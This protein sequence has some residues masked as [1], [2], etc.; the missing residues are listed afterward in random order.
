MILFS[1]E[2]EHLLDL[3]ASTKLAANE[4]SCH[5]GLGISY[6]SRNSINDNNKMKFGSLIIMACG[7]KSDPRDVCFFIHNV[8]YSSSDHSDFDGN[9]FLIFVLQVFYAS[10][11]TFQMSI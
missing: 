10:D 9:L 1:L 7:C 4:G 2:L 6:I 5:F 3:R 11:F 8:F